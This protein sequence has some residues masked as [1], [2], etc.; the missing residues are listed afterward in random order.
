MFPPFGLI[1]Y[2]SYSIREDSQRQDKCSDSCTRLVNLILV[3]A[4]ATDDQPRS[5]VFSAVMKKFDIATQTIREPSTMQ[6]TPNSNNQGAITT[7]K[8]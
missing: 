5:M 6:Q 1:G 4:V 2:R 7:E 8:F 3:P